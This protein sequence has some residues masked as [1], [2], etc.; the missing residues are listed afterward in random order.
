MEFTKSN[1]TKSQFKT[2]FGNK[3]T[4]NRPNI[5]LFEKNKIITKAW[6]SYHLGENSSCISSKFEPGYQEYFEYRF[7]KFEDNLPDEDTFIEETKAKWE[8]FSK[9][10]KQKFIQLETEKKS[11]L[12]KLDAFKIEFLPSLKKNFPNLGQKEEEKIIQGVYEA[13]SK[14]ERNEY[15]KSGSVLKSF[16]FENIYT[17]EDI[18]IF[19]SDFYFNS[20]SIRPKDQFFFLPLL[21]IKDK[22]EFINRNITPFYK[23]FLNYIKLEIFQ[24]KI[25]KIKFE[26]ALAWS[27]FH[28]NYLFTKFELNNFESF[29]NG[30]NFNFKEKKENKFKDKKKK[31]KY[32]SNKNNYQKK[33]YSNQN[34]N[35]KLL[36]TFNNPKTKNSKII[37][38]SSSEEETTD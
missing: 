29:K 10:K 8:S 14:N 35:N 26:A 15:K 30:I 23:Y 9:E 37:F 32:H 1:I 22:Y 6:Q 34:Q 31:N 7:E 21:N 28:P 25:E 11:K 3:L 20:P 17:L 2:Q 36:K 38:S 12:G 4:N 33:N 27:I 24:Q 5:S 16:E 19:I 18:K 13:L